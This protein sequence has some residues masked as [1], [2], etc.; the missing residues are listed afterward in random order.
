MDDEEKEIRRI[1]DAVA[2]AGAY[3]SGHIV[4][5][6]NLAKAREE[7]L[8]NSLIGLLGIRECQCNQ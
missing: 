5:M 6:K 3:E 7:K 8:K 1:L 2:K 4:W